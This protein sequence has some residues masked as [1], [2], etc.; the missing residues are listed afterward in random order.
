M[1]RANASCDPA[2]AG[3]IA[4]LVPD[5]VRD[6]H[7]RSRLLGLVR[8][9][10]PLTAIIFTITIAITA[11]LLGSGSRQQVIATAESELTLVARYAAAKI[12]HSSRDET[13]P[14]SISTTIPRSDGQFIVLINSDGKIV[15][16]STRTSIPV[17]ELNASFG[18]RFSSGRNLLNLA[19]QSANRILPMTL[20]DG[21]SALV[22]TRKIDGT[23]L[24]VLVIQKLSDRL[25]GWNDT[26]YRIGLLLFFTLSVFLV[27]S[28]AYMW[29][30]KRT[31][32]AT[33]DCLVLANCMDNALSHGHCG[34]WN[35]DIARGRVNWSTS[36]YQ[37]LGMEP[38][39]EPLSIKDINDMLHPDDVNLVAV[40][41]QLIASGETSID[42]TFRIRNVNGDW[43]WL[44]ARAEVDPLHP[45][46]S[47]QLVG[48]ALDIT[49]QRKLEKRT[50]TADSRLRAAVE[51]ISAAFV[52]WDAQDKLVLCNSK[53]LETYGL[54]TDVSYTGKDFNA[55]MGSTRQG[56]SDPDNNIIAP[57]NEDRR[58]LEVKIDNDRWLQINERRTIDGGYV[59]IGTDIS[60]LKTHE[61]QLLNSER[62]L[63]AT[64]ADLRKSRQTLENQ[65]RQLA[66]LAEQYL[67]QKRNAEQAYKAKSEFL[68]NMSH[69]LRT[70]LNSIIGFSDIMK[71]ELFGAMGSLKYVEYN[72]FIN[73]SGRYLLNVVSDV[74]D[75]ST[76]EAGEMEIEKSAVSLSDC[77]DSVCSQI[78]PLA[79]EKEIALEAG[80]CPDVI[81]DGDEEALFKIFDKLLRNAVKYT[82][83]AGTIS[84]NIKKSDTHVVVDIADTGIGIASDDINRVTKPFEQL[85]T[86]MSDGMKGSGLGLAIVKSLVKIHAGDLSISSKKGSGTCIS[87]TLPLKT[88]LPEAEYTITQEPEIVAG[89][90]HQND[91]FIQPTV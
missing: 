15:G 67:E 75:M 74:L 26:A 32:D 43:R 28:A 91:L 53:F 40:A 83:E 10:V 8:Y 81:I 86:P 38:Q 70:P 17:P 9:G 63:T 78:I 60:A 42:H 87:V 22:T 44:R 41:E 23:A 55:V 7:Y 2:L 79:E 66:V 49:E 71:G 64:V 85:I 34:L 59:S 33:L 80:V 46:G 89:L 77:L 5:A 90:G 27:M 72:S 52:L 62:R 21:A 4:N 50:Q 73:H 11:F 20:A 19:S 3:A 88:S 18:L 1:M 45:D 69:E 65:A 56:V 54:S 39:T 48:I 58:T 51:T 31:R 61:E 25:S 57:L 24:K 12:A 37:I 68:A 82:P 14:Q 29:Q 30:T 47:T 36:M 6:G 16:T 35:W 84:T 76:L 13:L